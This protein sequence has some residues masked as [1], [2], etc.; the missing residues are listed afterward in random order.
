MTTTNGY[1]ADHDLYDREP[2]RTR[3]STF[4]IAAILD[5]FPITV[6]VVGTSKDLLAAVQRLRDIGAVPPTAA[7]VQTAR[8]E[9]AREAP[10]CP[11]HGPMKE[12]TKVPGTWYCSKRM[13]DGSYCKEK[14]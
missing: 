2:Q 1:H 6:E 14:A 9:K 10:T 5:D 13:G 3:T 12:S 8:D 7:A 4:H 11:Y